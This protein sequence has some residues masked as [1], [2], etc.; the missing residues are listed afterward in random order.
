MKKAPILANEKQRLQALLDYNI[1]DTNPECD[2]D[3]ITRIAS[4]VCQTPIALIS[5]IDHE[6]QWF[7]SKQG[8]EAPET[9]RD[10]SFCG[11]AIHQTEVFIVSDSELDERFVDNPL[12]TG[13]PHVKFYAGAP[14]ITPDGF[15]IGTLCVIDQKRR[16]LTTEQV[17]ILQL[18]SKQ[19][20]QIF[21]LKKH[22]E[23]LRKHV[24][25]LKLATQLVQDRESYLIELSKLNFM[26]QLASGF[27]HEINNPLAIIKGKSSFLKAKLAKNNLSPEEAIIHLDKIDKATERIAVVTNSLQEL[28][29]TNTNSSASHSSD[30]VKALEMIIELFQG[31]APHIKW[32]FNRNPDENEFHIKVSLMQL[33]QGL[34]PVIQNAIESLLAHENP[35]IRIELKTNPLKNWIIEISNNGPLIEVSNYSKIFEP[36]MTTKLSTK[37]IGLGLAT[38]QSV[39]FK[40]GIDIAVGISSQGWQSFIIRPLEA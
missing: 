32:E 27:A 29:Q 36:F 33:I 28:A 14:L 35:M 25:D 15:G 34:S 30:L 16:T 5:L 37:N 8:L 31:Q 11:H 40:N 17:Q 13:N 10:I 39:F 6:R 1:L 7:K 4:L 9:P 24:T 12:Y 22:H 3:E 18:L 26:N 20:I 38:A 23:Q 19:V 2:L 21:E